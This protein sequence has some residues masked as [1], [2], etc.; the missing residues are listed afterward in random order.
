MS[1]LQISLLAEASRPLLDKFYRQHQSS[2]RASAKGQL[3]VVRD[4]EIIAGMSLAPVEHGHWLTGLFVAP[5]SRGQGLAAQLVEQALKEI[6]GPVWL[7]CHPDLETLYQRMSF[8][9][10]TQLPRALGERLARYRRNK[11]LL[12]M[13]TESRPQE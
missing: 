1:S 12:A 8:S 6:E 5:A 2:M 3:W 9:T 7:F 13:S 11:P 4:T 10:A